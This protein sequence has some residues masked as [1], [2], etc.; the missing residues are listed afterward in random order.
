MML[1]TDIICS[2]TAILINVLHVLIIYVKTFKTDYIVFISN[3]IKCLRSH[4]IIFSITVSP[5]M[6]KMSICEING[7]IPKWL[8]VYHVSLK[9]FFYFYLNN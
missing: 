4:R 5:L 6:L 9:R 8:M 7:N 2:I 3:M 1:K